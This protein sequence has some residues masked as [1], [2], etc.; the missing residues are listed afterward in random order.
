MLCFEVLELQMAPMTVEVEQQHAAALAD[1][2]HSAAEPFAP[3][4]A[5][6]DPG[7]RLRNRGWRTVV[8]NL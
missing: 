3:P 7:T 2:A 6:N 4:A 1:F 5:A 8:V